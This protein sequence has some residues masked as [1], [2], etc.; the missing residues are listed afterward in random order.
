[1]AG[2]KVQNRRRHG[3]WT[4]RWEL[5]TEKQ[6]ALYYRSLNTFGDWRK[7]LLAPDG[8]VIARQEW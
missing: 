7:R 6:A 5:P 4:T 3:K 1:M 2:Y 8:T